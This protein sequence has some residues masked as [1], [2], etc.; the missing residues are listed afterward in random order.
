[1]VAVLQDHFKRPLADLNVLNVGSSV[2]IIDNYL[3]NHFRSVTGIDIDAPAIEKSQSRFIKTNLK[4]QTGDA[5]NLDFAD[6]SFDVVICSQ[7]YEHVPD[8]EKMMREINRVLIPGGACYFAAGNRLMWNEPHYNLPLLS[9]LPRPLAHLYVRIAKKASHYHELHYTYFGLKKLAGNFAVNDY[10][11]K[12]VDDP[13]KFHTQYMLPPGSKK[14]RIAKLIT[15]RIMWLSP[16]FIWILT[17][18]ITAR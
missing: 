1:M 10:T 13:A 6:A 18:P 14:A 7:V 11:K 17:K 15:H 12:V 2:G 5:L 16:G 9:V 4:F 3:A 8:P